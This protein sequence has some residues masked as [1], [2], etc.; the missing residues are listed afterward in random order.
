MGLRLAEGV[1][2]D[3]IAIRGGRPFESA[4]DPAMLEAC[5]EAGYLEWRGGRLLATGEGRMRLDAMLPRLLA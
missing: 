4:L 2:P 5:L 3:R 1:D